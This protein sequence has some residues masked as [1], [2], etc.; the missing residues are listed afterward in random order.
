MINQ[1]I[2][3]PSR[4]RSI[5]HSKST[6]ATFEP[7]YAATKKDLECLATKLDIAQLEIRMLNTMAS[8]TEMRMLIGGLYLLITVGFLALTFVGK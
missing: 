8:K 4:A 3:K 6:K 2:N 1:E 7:D 5:P